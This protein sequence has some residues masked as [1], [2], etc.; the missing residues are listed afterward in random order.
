MFS[1]AWDGSLT[2][3]FAEQECQPSVASGY[4]ESK[5]RT[6]RGKSLDLSYIWLDL[7]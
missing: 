4:Y 6:L 2:L 1:G 3:D 5:N 7:I